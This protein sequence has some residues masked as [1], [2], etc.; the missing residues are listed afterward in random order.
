MAKELM[1]GTYGPFAVEVYECDEPRKN[2]VMLEYDRHE[3]YFDGDD[4][5]ELLRALAQI[6]ELLSMPAKG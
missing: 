2:R 5:P 1:H 4:M 3:F 6:G